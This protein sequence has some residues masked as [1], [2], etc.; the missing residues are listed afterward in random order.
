MA[1]HTNSIAPGSPWT[2]FVLVA[3]ATVSA[4][5]LKTVVRLE[6]APRLPPGPRL[7]PVLGNAL[8]VPRSSFGPSWFA[9]SRKFGTSLNVRNV[10]SLV[11]RPRQA[12]S[13]ISM[14]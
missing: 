8:N 3:L 9:L 6:G 13:S 11:N 4:L 1:S 5:L 2:V 10:R 12:T 7:L 14:S